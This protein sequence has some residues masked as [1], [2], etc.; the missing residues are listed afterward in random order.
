[1]SERAEIRGLW[2]GSFQYSSSA[3]VGDFPFKA[4]IVEKDGDVSGLI[5]ED[6]LSG[7]TVKAEIKGRLDGRAISFTKTYLTEKD[8]YAHAVQ[9]E[10]Q[11]SADGTAISGTWRLPHDGGTFSM[12]RSD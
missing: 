7:G 8:H 5:I 12:I 2:N 11:I 10:G 1:M 6:S 9:Y 4:K 3:D